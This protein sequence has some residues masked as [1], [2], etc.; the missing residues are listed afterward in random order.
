[1]G[2]RLSSLNTHRA[3]HWAMVHDPS[4]SNHR[5]PPTLDGLAMMGRRSISAGVSSCIRSNPAT[6]LRSTPRPP[7]RGSGRLL[8]APVE[9]SNLRS[10]PG[11]S[12]P[13]QRC[14][15]ATSGHVCTALISSVPSGRHLL[16]SGPAPQLVHRRLHSKHRYRLRRSFAQRAAG[17]AGSRHSHD[18]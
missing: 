14:A 17:R 18:G 16:L 4:T 12:D 6:T 15:R 8:P 1:M 11:R 5:G 13:P 3:P 7:E 10:A 9:C 2:G